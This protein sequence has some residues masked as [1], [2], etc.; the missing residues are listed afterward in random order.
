MNRDEKAA[1]AVLGDLLTH[2]LFEDHVPDDTP[3][4]PLDWDSML[5]DDRFGSLS[6]GETKVFFLS[7]AVWSNCEA[8]ATDNDAGV[9][10][11]LSA[12]DA[13][14]GRRILEG[15]ALRFGINEA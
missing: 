10:A 1:R 9:F 12:V 6:T 4:L 5:N 13:Y 2:Y 15:L 14:T 3:G 8:I 7:W 11:T